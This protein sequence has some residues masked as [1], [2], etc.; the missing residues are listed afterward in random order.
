[1]N[2]KIVTKIEKA[3]NQYY[4]LI[5]IAGPPDSGKTTILQ[6]ISQKTGSEILNVNLELSGNLLD[7]SKKERMM[8]AEKI[9]DEIISARYSADDTVLLD[10]TE[11]LFDIEL[12]T[13]PLKLLQNLSRNRSIVSTWNGVVSN[14]LL[15]YGNPDH[16]E[17]RKYNTKDLI[18]INTENKT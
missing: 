14:D 12:K 15:I 8:K 7:L 6:D 16:A 2:D 4:R 17:Y 5:L 3:K 18:I 11:I 13:D 1:M 9:L 10:N